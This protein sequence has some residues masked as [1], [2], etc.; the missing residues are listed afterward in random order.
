MKI[1]GKINISGMEYEVI[2]KDQPLFC[3]NTRAYGHIDFD[4]KQILIDNTLRD[5]QGHMQTLLHEII[6]GIT[7]DRDIDFTQQGEETI[8]DQLAKGLYQVLKDNKIF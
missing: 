8:V 7:N 6:H 4:S 2:I 1:P 5:S 3:G